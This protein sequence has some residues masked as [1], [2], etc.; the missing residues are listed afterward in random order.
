M[1]YILANIDIS[2]KEPVVDGYYGGQHKKYGSLF[3][4]APTK[5]E[6]KMFYNEH[7]VKHIADILNKG[8]GYNFKVVQICSWCN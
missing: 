2:G 5:Q 3:N 1:T 8:E 7:D 4:L 6:A